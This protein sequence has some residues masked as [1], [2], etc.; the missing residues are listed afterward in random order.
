MRSSTLFVSAAAL[1]LCL[2]PGHSTLRAD[3]GAGQVLI[4]VATMAPRSPE[5]VRREKRYNQIIGQETSGRIQFRT[6]WGGVAGDEQTVMREQLVSRP[7]PP[8]LVAPDLVGERLPGALHEV[9]EGDGRRAR[10]LAPPA[11]HA[12]VHA[13][14]EVA[15][16]LGSSEVHR[17]HRRDADRTV[18][19]GRSASQASP[20]LG[21]HP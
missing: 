11:L 6:Y 1:C 9:A 3:D 16:G 2:L 19:V 5:F 10:R 8:G 20:P 17:P 7:P 4:K 13:L 15:V 18:G 21:L 14:H 12:R